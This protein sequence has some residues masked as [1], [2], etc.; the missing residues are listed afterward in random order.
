MNN[1]L[2]HQSSH[3]EPR[4]HGAIPLIVRPSREPE[5]IAANAEL[6]SESIAVSAE[7]PTEA[8]VIVNDDTA[9]I[10]L[11]LTAGS[12][13]RLGQALIATVRSLTASESPGGP[14]HPE[15]WEE[16]A[17]GPGKPEPLGPPGDPL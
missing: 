3:N 2:A 5:F 15:P 7:L 17:E 4:W 6:L 16:P 1:S 13:Q 14:L 10:L 11:E 12:A 9:G 8:V